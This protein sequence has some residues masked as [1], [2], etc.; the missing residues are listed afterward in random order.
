[1]T[2]RMQATDAEADD[3]NA[4]A[5]AR[6]STAGTAPS[7]RSASKLGNPDFILDGDLPKFEQ[8]QQG[9]EQD[10]QST[11]EAEE[12]KQL[13]EKYAEASQ[14]YF[15]SVI[16]RGEILAA[17]RERKL[18]RQH[19]PTFDQYCQRQLRVKRKRG[20]RYSPSCG[21]RLPKSG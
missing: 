15:D 7:R 20:Y 14:T 19:Y 4:N 8:N 6:D 16:V 13:E 9:A 12:L 3:D 21:W 5:P 11:D 10:R 1:M 18:Y 17:I 2:E